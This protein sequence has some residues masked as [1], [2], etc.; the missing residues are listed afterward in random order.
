MLSR[1]RAHPIDWLDRIC[2]SSGN[3]TAIVAVRLREWHKW[4][5]SGYARA[6]DQLPHIRGHRGTLLSTLLWVC[7][8]ASM[9]GLNGCDQY[10]LPT[11]QPRDPL[12][13]DLPDVPT[14]DFGA[15]YLISY[16]TVH[17]DIQY[18]GHTLPYY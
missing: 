13:T 7:G 3:T 2:S 8:T 4:V 10:L 15:P 17:T 14:K 6:W 1:K 12:P 16:C 9:A 18:L 11:Q 5:K